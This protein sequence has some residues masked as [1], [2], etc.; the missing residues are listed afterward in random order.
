MPKTLYTA[1]YT[2]S[3]DKH[4]YTSDNKLIQYFIIKYIQHQG[5]AQLENAMHVFLTEHAYITGIFKIISTLFIAYLL[6]F[7]GAYL[8]PVALFIAYLLPLFGAYLLSIGLIYCLFVNLIWCLFVASGLIY[9][10]FVNLIWYLFVDGGP[11]LLL[12]CFLIW[13]LFVAEAHLHKPYL[14]SLISE[15]NNYLLLICYLFIAY[16]LKVFVASF[17]GLGG[18]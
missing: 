12:I 4:V 3:T 18:T 13:Y 17:F 15:N 11:Y 2:S 10:L 8:L 16:L 9:C 7:F 5:H 1:L 6:P 14:L